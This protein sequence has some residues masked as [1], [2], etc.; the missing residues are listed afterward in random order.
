[1]MSGS[2]LNNILLQDPG[3]LP[4]GT[5]A[6]PTTSGHRPC[7]SDK[8]LRSACQNALVISALLLQEPWHNA[9]LNIICEVMRSVEAWRRNQN[10]CLRDTLSSKKWQV[11]Q[12]SGNFW[13]HVAKTLRVLLSQISVEY[14]GIIL[15]SPDGSLQ[16]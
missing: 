1:M 15:P 2:K 3:T 13:K 4:D 8:D 14:I 12:A 9:L 6:P 11:E 5:E 16:L 10:T 7:I